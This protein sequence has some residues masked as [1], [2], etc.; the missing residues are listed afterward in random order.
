VLGFRL[1]RCHRESIFDEELP[2]L[3]EILEM[4][5]FVALFGAAYDNGIL[6]GYTAPV[7]EAAILRHWLFSPENRSS[8]PSQR[9]YDTPSSYNGPRHV[10]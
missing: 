3:G 8:G 9:S 10:H 2:V 4:P 7:V 5:G 6:A 1:A